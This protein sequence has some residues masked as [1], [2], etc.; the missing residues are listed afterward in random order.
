MVSPKEIHKHGQQ[1][2]S[3]DGQ[4][5]SLQTIVTAVRC[6]WLIATPIGLLLAAVTGAAVWY[7]V[8]PTYTAA[9]WLIIREHPVTILKQFTLE[10]P[11]RF[12]QNQLEL[13][14]S[15][16]VIDFVSVM[17]D[18]KDTPELAHE[19]DVGKALQRLMK[20]RQ[21]GK[22]HFYVVEF[23]STSGEHAMAVVNKLAKRFIDVQTKDESERT[24]ATIDLL[25]QRQAEQEASVRTSRENVRTLAVQRT[26]K[27][28]FDARPQEEVGQI[29]SPIAEIQSQLIE[30]EVDAAVYEAQAQVESQ[31]LEKQS[32]EVPQAAVDRFV[33]EHPRIAAARARLEVDRTKMQEYEQASKDLQSNSTYQQ[34]KK[35]VAN[36]ET[37]LDKQ[38]SEIRSSSQEE[39]ARQ[40]R[41]AQEDQVNS[42][43]RR[44][45][46]AQLTVQVLKEKYD[47]AFKNQKE[48]TGDSLDLEFRRA[49]YER[50]SAVY[51]AIADRILT[52]EMEQR[53]PERV[54]LH[55]QMEEPPLPDVGARI[56]K[57]LMGS[58]GAFCF[59][60]V[61][62]V[63]IEHL[64]RR[65]SHRDQLERSGGISVVGEVTVLPRRAESESSR[66]RKANRELQLFQETV[67]GLRTVL[68]LGE[69]LKNVRVIA[70]TSAVSREGK[71]SLGVQLAIS[72]ARASSERTLLIDGDMRSPDLHRSFDVDRSPGLADLLEGKCSVAE[73]VRSTESPNIDVLPAGNLTTSPHRVM[74]NGRFD[75]L[76]DQLRATYSHIIID[77]PPVLAAS[78]ALVMTRVADVALLCV[79]RDFSRVRQVSEAFARLQKAGVK[80]AGAVLGGIP[81]REYIYRYG[82][83]YIENDRELGAAD[84]QEMEA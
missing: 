30:A 84:S 11:A 82:S 73:A 26:G 75:R 74:G 32:S 47:A 18:V 17:P 70:V 10:D 64:Y 6:W 78:E 2:A 58:A 59:P 55:Y 15:P 21:V 80:T 69:T 25:K 9:A 71:T 43:R 68:T 1:P 61:L 79:R 13:M 27:N 8:K 44:Q 48:Y 83:Y 16:I 42:L 49:E 65:V 50:A 53:A 33:E 76:V 41:M 4:Q 20:F 12:V 57:V 51:Q 29:R 52:I 24:K 40:L 56:K 5:F 39:L 28:P 23:T 35:Q 81:P 46:N 66:S 37:V 36:A 72:V 77:T 14:R 63:C 19:G 60:F 45:E 54:T 31:L 22:S 3:A 38:I 7:Y 34:L 67:D 62:A